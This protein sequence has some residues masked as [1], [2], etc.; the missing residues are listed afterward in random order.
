M[1]RVLGGLSLA[2]CF[3]SGAT[4][5]SAEPTI[6]IAA[7]CERS[8]FE[9][10]LEEND[11]RVYFQACETEEG[12]AAVLARPGSGRRLIELVRVERRG[13]RL[14]VRVGSVPLSETTAPREVAPILAALARPE[15][16]LAGRSLWR[17]VAASGFTRD[18]H[19]V[20]TS[21]LAASLAAIEVGSPA[22]QGVRTED[23]PECLGCCGDGCDGCMGC[24]T[25]ACYEHDR[26]IRDA[27][28]A[29]SWSPQM[30]CLHLLMAAVASAWE[31]R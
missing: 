5:T 31:C 20:A 9:G 21:A 25:R 23:D 24:Y 8:G 14:E 13:S 7:A 28:T 30:R 19:P 12:G 26:C 3:L 2:V 6:R 27:V 17:A 18:S 1:R 10:W 16:R 22:P 11:V 4:A 29:G 15:L